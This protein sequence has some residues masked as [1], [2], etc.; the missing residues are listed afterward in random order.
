MTDWQDD[1]G[2]NRSLPASYDQARLIPCPTCRAEVG[3]VCTGTFVKSGKSVTF[4]R[5]HMPCVSRLSAHKVTT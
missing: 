1:M 5:R 2:G 4:E 3:M